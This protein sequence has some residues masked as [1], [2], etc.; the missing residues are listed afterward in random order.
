MMR[1]AL[2]TLS[3]WAL[4]ASA[5]VAQQQVQQVDVPPEIS[6]ALERTDVALD[7]VMAWPVDWTAN[8]DLLV[9]S[10]YAFIGGNGVA[11]IS[12]RIV[13]LTSEG[14]V[15]AEE[16]DLP[17]AGIE[18]V[19]PHPQGAFLVVYDY[20]DGDPRCCPSGRLQVI[21]ARPPAP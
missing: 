11:E 8:P 13:S 17:G 21:L 1:R 20:R 19:T 6:A 3:L 4:A 9:Q 16:F 10:V 15:F 5:A 18:S 12:W 7:S 14:P 2:A